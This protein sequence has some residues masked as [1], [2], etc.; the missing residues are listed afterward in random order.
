MGAAESCLQAMMVEEDQDDDDSPEDLLARFSIDYGVKYGQG[1]FGV[2]YQALDTATRPPTLCAVK[3]IDISQMSLAKIKREVA[4]ARK[5]K[6]ANVVA[7]H[8]AARRKQEYVI[9]ME[10]CD[11]K[12]PSTRWRRSAHQRGAGA[13]L[14]VQLMA[15]VAYLHGIGIVHRDLKLENV[16]LTSAG[17]L[18]II[19]F[20]LAHEHARD[21]KSGAV[22]E[23]TLYDVCGSKS[24]C[25]PEVLASSGYGFGVDVWSCGVALFAM[26][27]AF[28][29]L[30]EASRKDWR[31]TELL[32]AQEA[33]TATVDCVLGWYKKPN[34]LS[35]DGSD[36][37]HKM[38]TVDPRRRAT[39]AEIV[40]H[41]WMTARGSKLW[42]L[43]GSAEPAAGGPVYCAA[44]GSWAAAAPTTSPP[45]ACRCRP[46]EEAGALRRRASV[47]SAP[48]T[49][50]CRVCARTVLRSGQNS[51]SS[52]LVD[53]RLERHRGD[54][55]RRRRGGALA[56]RE[57]EEVRVR[58][59]AVEQLEAQ[60][61]EHRQ[62]RREVGKARAHLRNL[63]ERARL[64][65]A[66]RFAQKVDVVRAHQ[67]E[68]ATRRRASG[69][70]RQPRCRRPAV[71]GDEVERGTAST[72][73][74]EPR[75]APRSPT[76]HVRCAR[77]RASRGAPGDGQRA[78]CSR[79]PR[80]RRAPAAPKSAT[81]SAEPCVYSSSLMCRN[82]APASCARAASPAD[83]FAG[84]AEVSPLA[85]GFLPFCRLRFF[86]DG[87]A[88]G[89]GAAGRGGGRALG[90][91]KRAVKSA[92]SSPR[93]ARVRDLHSDTWTPELTDCGGCAFAG[94]LEAFCSASCRHDGEWCWR[95][96]LTPVQGHRPAAAR[97]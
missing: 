48:Q 74:G 4:I 95:L 56:E 49:N 19:D 28:F 26:L 39:C 23:E 22:R 91:P 93:C 51:L 70:P 53:A 43:R 60:A 32:R 59:I 73:R 78:A 96:A 45:S 1:G 82:R 8:G 16:M 89:G 92:I 87:A 85:A 75:R 27:L 42:G 77:S 7:T 72:A 64:Q 31:F 55:R 65:H 69:R 86:D 47:T 36:L 3:V 80:T 46:H 9:F 54:G 6:H 38:L 88:S 41:P 24:Y 58:A 66:A 76:T 25:A 57:E 97:F 17:G 81:D 30:E 90:A 2:T 50:L 71:V 13:R 29:P 68:A 33:G 40:R 37:L 61:V 79:S 5:L 62:P 84:A 15:G 83:F 94:M 52:P 11:G 21:P 14:A 44:T 18:K 63:E 12:E 10:L 34:P 20:G 67:R 35:R